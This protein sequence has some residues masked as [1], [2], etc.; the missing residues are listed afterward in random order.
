M[1]NYRRGFKGKDWEKCWHWKEQCEAYPTI[2]C[3][4]QN[5]RPSDEE[6]CQRCQELG[7]EQN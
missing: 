3:I 5:E 6:L 7:R 2:N 1:T 4:I